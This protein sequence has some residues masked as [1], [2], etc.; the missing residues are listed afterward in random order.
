MSQKLKFMMISAMYENGGNT[1]H[2]MLDGH[3]ELHVYPFESQLGTA[4]HG[5]HVH[6]DWLSSFIPPRYRWPEFPMHGELARDYEMF[7][8]EEMKTVLRAP[9]RSK[10]RDAGLQLNEDDRKKAF[11]AYMK[12]NERTR[13]NLVDAF[14]ISTFEAWKNLKKT[15]KEKAYLGYSP[16][17]GVD[18][19]KMMADFPDGHVI[20]VV[21][22][23]YSGYADTKKRPFP[24]TLNRY[25]WKWSIM[26]H[27]A[28]TFSERYPKNFHIIRFEDIVEDP[29]KAFKGLCKKLGLS[30]SPTC[31]YPSWNSTKLESVY[32]WGTIR[33]P[34]PEAN[35]A[36]MNEL[37]AAEKKEMRS[38]TVVMRRLLG[39]EKW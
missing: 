18:G 8:D 34:T 9:S 24:I 13:A 3:P 32:P 25:A 1:T 5:F 39:Y 33:T 27:M 36:T 31:E 14:F 7:W 23:P 19:D 20:H 16:V 26:Q 30:Y 12:G 11:F 35:V 28:L 38:L 21:R 29:K 6:N 15:G 10:F 17:I 4:D 37:N 22:N 2:R